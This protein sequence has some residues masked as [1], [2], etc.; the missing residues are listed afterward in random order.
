MLLLA[1]AA[2]VPAIFWQRVWFG[3][4]LSDDEI[5]RRLTRPAGSR[6]VQHACEQ[7]S[8]RM[9]SDPDSARSFYDLLSALADS[10][11][12]HIRSVVAWC[13]GEDG[14]R[15]QP[16]HDSLRALAGDDAPSVRFNAALALVRFGDPAARPVLREMLTSYTVAARWEGPS[17]DGRLIDM[18][19]TRDPVRPLM[20][21][22][23][24]DTG[25]GELKPVLAP[26]GGSVDRLMARLGHRL[27]KGE[28]LCTIEPSS[29]QVFEALRALAVAGEGEDLELVERY[30][31]PSPRFP[32]PERVRLSAQARLTAD[33]I[34][35]RAS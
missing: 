35:K 31:D 18:L 23:L 25:H 5:R 10:E 22:A 15:Y 26:L 32:P 27:A 8:R 19:H 29:P 17:E 20:Q 11:D 9:Q 14:S 28:P 12:E 7:I 13:M 33:A 3:S 6:E 16:F 2:A 1:A 21:L 34:R 30:C 24:V 4:R